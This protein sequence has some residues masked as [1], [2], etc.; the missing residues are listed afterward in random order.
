MHPIN[1]NCASPLIKLQF[2][3]F[4]IKLSCHFDAFIYVN[5]FRGNSNQK[6]VAERLLF[7]T[8]FNIH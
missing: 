1:I 6:H 2:F 5:T 7:C 4:T 3:F 8:K